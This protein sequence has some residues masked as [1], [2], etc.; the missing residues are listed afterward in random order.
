MGD[1]TK[2]AEALAELIAKVEAGWPPDIDTPYMRP[3]NTVFGMGW[4]ARAAY[5]ANQGSLDAAKALHEAVLGDEWTW[6]VY[7]GDQASV[8]LGG[9]ADDGEYFGCFSANPAR[10]WLLAILRALA[11]QE[12]AKG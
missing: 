11:Q 7:D 1:T 3:F 12:G 6:I 4:N 9:S 8:A 10:A 5:D 2:R